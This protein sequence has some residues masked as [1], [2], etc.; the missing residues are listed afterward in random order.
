MRM[1][2]I[3][4]VMAPLLIGISI[5]S[6]SRNTGTENEEPAKVGDTAIVGEMAKV[7]DTAKVNDTI[8]PRHPKNRKTFRHSPILL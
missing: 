5:V 2:K 7:G 3:I 6:C 1:K 4:A 8:N